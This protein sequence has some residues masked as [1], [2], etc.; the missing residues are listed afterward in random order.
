MTTTKK[1]WLPDRKVLA[2]GV[3]GVLTWLI[4]LLLIQL[5]VE[6]PAEA[7]GGIVAGVMALVAYAVPPSV[8]DVIERVDDTLKEAFAEEV[9]AKR[10]SAD[11]L[12]KAAG[13]VS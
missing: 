1:S 7:L 4:G 6:M 13:N 11:A 8:R 10:A 5:G 12:V 9:Q 3:S 2:S